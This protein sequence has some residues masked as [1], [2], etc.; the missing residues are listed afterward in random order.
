MP[1]GG[2]RR[3]FFRFWG[4]GVRGGWGGGGGLV[5]GTSSALRSEVL[6]AGDHLSVSASTY[7][8]EMAACWNLAFGC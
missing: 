5:V 4:E 2:F 3:G 6:R 7:D 8:Y 1:G